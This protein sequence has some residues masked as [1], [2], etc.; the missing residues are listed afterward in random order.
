MSRE[1]LLPATLNDVQI[2]EPPAAGSDG[3]T[4]VKTE[5]GCSALLAPLGYDQIKKPPAVSMVSFSY[6]AMDER[7]QDD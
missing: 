2:K 5:A 4:A 7:C 6:T 1:H 3:R